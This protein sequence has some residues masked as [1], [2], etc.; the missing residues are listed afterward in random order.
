MN[1]GTRC[2]MTL[3]YSNNVSTTMVYNVK[4][5]Y[6]VYDHLEPMEGAEKGLF[7]FYI[8][9]LSYDGL[10]FKNGKW[11]MVENV[12]AFNDKKQDGKQ[13]KNIERGIQGN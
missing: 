10:T 12:P 8:P 2:R 4:N 7:E 6:I 13:T 5:E 1:D 3:E 9:S 11:R